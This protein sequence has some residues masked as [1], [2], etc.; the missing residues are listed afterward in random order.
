MTARDGGNQIKKRYSAIVGA[1][2]TTQV[3]VPLIVT[4]G[5]SPDRNS[6]V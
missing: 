3:Q 2:A 5:T 1:A 6:V 4:T